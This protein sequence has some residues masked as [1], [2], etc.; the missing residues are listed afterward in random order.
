[1]KSTICLNVAA[2]LLAGGSLRGAAAAQPVYVYLHA[3]IGDHVNID[4]SEDRLR[5]ILPMVERYRKQHPQ[6]GVSATIL[7]SGA[8]SQA[9]ADRN[10]K[11]GIKDFV[12]DY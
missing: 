9:L 2:M 7:F 11:T 1:M 5:R 6:A 8:V 10:A 3:R 12:Q 4:L